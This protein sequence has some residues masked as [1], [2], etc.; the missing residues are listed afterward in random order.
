MIQAGAKG[1][2]RWVESLLG[3]PLFISNK[4]RV[5]QVEMSEEKSAFYLCFGKTKFLK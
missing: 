1:Q 2:V 5:T 3:T 4:S